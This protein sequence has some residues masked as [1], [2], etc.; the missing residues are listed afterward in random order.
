MA[1]TDVEILYCWRCGKHV[2][3]GPGKCWYCNAATIRTIRPPRHCPFC[4]QVIPAKAIKCHH[5]GEFLDGRA[6]PEDVALELEA[7]RIQQE[8][9]LQQQQ[10]Q[11]QQP[12]QITFVIDKAVIGSDQ[13]LMLS[14]G[15]QLPPDVQGR[16]TQ[17]TARAI[18]SNSPDL[19][20]Q[21]GIQAL[22]APETATPAAPPQ[23]PAALPPAQ[24][25]AGSTPPAALPGPGVE[26]PAAGAGPASPAAPVTPPG[27][28][29]PVVPSATEGQA[30]VR[31]S[32]P[33]GGA[34]V[35]ASENHPVVPY[36][37]TPP[38]KT[39]RKRKVKRKI[40]KTK[41][42]SRYAVCKVCLT[43]V[44]ASDNYCFHCGTVLRH[45]AAGKRR[46]ESIYYP[47]NAAYYGL[48]LFLMALYVLVGLK[49][50]IIGYVGLELPSVQVVLGLS[51]VS[52]LLLVAAFFRR[53]TSFSQIL[54]VFFLVLWS[55]TTVVGLFF[56]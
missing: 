55:V 40:K 45:E 5:C 50:G 56:K 17:Q 21:P 37:E 46:K 15:Q 2:K 23:P 33:G 16:L 54:T 36:Q 28:Q 27:G 11:H 48:S 44:L 42:E 53:R 41:V 26:I 3:R 43:E 30:P 8:Q 14:G 18:A 20:D 35:P 7:S 49:P 1:E 19:I 32:Q 6:R 12:Q 38:K 47:S 29:F 39:A 34:L 4:E 52:L 10:L 13:P 22:P 31:A 9:Q 51:G 24:D 25:V